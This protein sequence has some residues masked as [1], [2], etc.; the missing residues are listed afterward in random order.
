MWG[1]FGRRRGPRRALGW[2][3]IEPFYQVQGHPCNVGQFWKK[4]I[5]VVKH[6]TILPGTGSTMPCGAILEEE[7][8][9]EH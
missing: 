9:E 7:G 6:W 8:Q 5:R 1:N 4:S 3:H 2:L